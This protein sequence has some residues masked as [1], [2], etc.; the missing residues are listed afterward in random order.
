MVWQGSVA[1]L[2]LPDQKHMHDK[3]LNSKF[4]KDKKPQTFQ[5]ETTYQCVIYLS[6][7]SVK[8]TDQIMLQ[9]PMFLFPILILS[10]HSVMLGNY[11][12]GKIDLIVACIEFCPSLWT[13]LKKARTSHQGMT[14]RN[15]V[16]FISDF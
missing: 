8:F 16:H 13:T 6:L 5:V 11:H 14:L 2:V 9:C 12:S 7:R 10:L 15:N 4:I 3:W 1:R